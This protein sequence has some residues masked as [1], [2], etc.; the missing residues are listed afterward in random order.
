MSKFQFKINRNK[1]IFYWC[2]SLLITYNRK[3][4]LGKKYNYE[5]RVLLKEEKKIIVI[6]QKVIKNDNMII[7]SEIVFVIIYS[8]S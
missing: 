1:H 6:F 2:L 7:V 5:S 4:I 3:T 8:P